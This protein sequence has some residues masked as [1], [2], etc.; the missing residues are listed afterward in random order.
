MDINQDEKVCDV[1]RIVAREPYSITVRLQL[2]RLYEGLGYADL[3]TGEA[4]MAILLL[5]ELS[6]ESG[7][8]HERVVEGSGVDPDRTGDIT[9]QTVELST[10]ALAEAG[11]LRS[12]R[13]QTLTSNI[14]II[15]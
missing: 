6:D 5:D 10:E 12:G 2:A 13:Q 11:I 15:F 3:A 7:E 8:Y 14:V 9:S 1:Q 4:Y